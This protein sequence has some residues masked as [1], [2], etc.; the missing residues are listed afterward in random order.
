[1]N[2][3][4]VSR[5]FWPVAIIGYF[6]LGITFL[7]IFIVWSARQREDLVSNNYYETEIRYQEQVDRLIHSQEFESLPIVTYESARQ[8][9]VI[10]LPKGRSKDA[11]GTVRLYRPSDARL[12]RELSLTVDDQGVQLLD[13]RPL[14]PG[15]WKVRVQW[16]VAGR[17]YYCDR[18]VVVAG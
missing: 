10:T 1:M 11:S 2:N 3:K 16:T 15:L 17:E 18:S 14:P 6:V 12:D 8:T 13:A 7:V 4:T 9:I 5:S